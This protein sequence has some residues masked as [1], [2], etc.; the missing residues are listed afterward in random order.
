MHGGFF[1]GGVTGTQVDTAIAAAVASLRTTPKLKAGQRL[2]HMHAYG[3]S[4]AASPVSANF[5]YALPFAVFSPTSV[6]AIELNV[7]TL[8]AGLA[9]VGVGTLNGDGSAWGMTLVSDIAALDLS[10]TGVKSSAFVYEFQPGVIYLA[11]LLANV[12]FSGTTVVNSRDLFGGNS[13]ANTGARLALTVV[14][15]YAALPASTTFS[16]TNPQAPLL[17]FVVA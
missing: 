5:I 16:A 17:H 3:G 13:G 4:T 10:S 6:S 2:G 12:G 9:R 1:T 11:L 14:Q 7:T 15:A 8:G